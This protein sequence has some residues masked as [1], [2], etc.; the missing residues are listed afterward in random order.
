MNEL[1]TLTA[2]E[3]ASRLNRSAATLERWRRLRVGP[4]FYRIRGR[5]AYDPADVARWIE[6]QKT[7]TAEGRR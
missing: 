2:R 3:L 5:V 6:Q 4:P 7:S 1:N